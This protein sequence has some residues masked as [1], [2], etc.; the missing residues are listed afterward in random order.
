MRTIKLT[1]LVFSFCSFY[2]SAEITPVIKSSVPVILKSTSSPA[3][4]AMINRFVKTGT[5]YL[6]SKEDFNIKKAEACLDSANAYCDSKDI[7]IPAKLHLLSAEFNFIA[8]D[9]SKSEEEAKLAIEKAEE[10][11]ENDVLVKAM[12][13][14][15][16]YYLRTGFFQESINYLDK[17]IALSK[18]KEIK[19]TI[20]KAYNIKA[21]VLNAAKDLNGYRKNLVLM[22]EAAADEKDTVSLEEGLLRLGNLFVEKMRDFRLCDSLLRKC[23]EIS[24]IRRDNYYSAFASANLGYNYYLEKNYDSSMMFY[25][26]S[27]NYSQS[28]K[29]KGLS[30]NSL[31]NLGTI[32]RD[33]GDYEKAL[34]Y[35]RKSIEDAAGANDFYNLSWVYKDMSQLYLSIGDTANAYNNYVLFKKFNDSLLIKSSTQGLSDA[36]IRYEADAHNK[37]IALLSLRLKN[38]R[39][40]NIGFTIFII[41]T[42]AIG[43]LI[44]RS[45][46]IEAKR[47]I[48]EMNHKISEITQ[49][50]LRQQMNPHFIFN[51]LNS[52]QY[53]MY[54]NDKLA[55]NNYLTKFSTLMRKVL[56]NSQHTSIPLRDELEALKLYLDLECLRF[57]DKFDYHISVDEEIDPLLFKVPTMLIQPYVENSICHGLVAKEGKGTVKIDMKLGRGQIICTIEDNG[58]GRE[59]AQERKKMK[60]ANHNSL[61]TK[62][63]S[64]RLDLVNALYGT[65]LKTVYTDLKNDKGEPEGTRVEIHIPIMT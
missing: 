36:R 45:S 46:K 33:L 24:L 51:T 22:I 42:I 56:E 25:K 52:I 28:G 64:S 9:Y 1:L 55:T 39:I 13:F 14:I 60:E 48:S 35:Y 3:D 8:G 30:A 19:G 40:L 53:F 11:G 10:A 59:A 27:L 18:S 58:I 50:N 4:T 12:L 62:I 16:R 7:E 61:G 43:L 29:G 23:V 32:Y 34:K 65:S 57:K 47:R 37:E 26:R 31:G 44:I 41:L 6:S 63:V 17:S 38:N 21:D 5:L 15:A 20:Q 49:A 2:V 54:Q